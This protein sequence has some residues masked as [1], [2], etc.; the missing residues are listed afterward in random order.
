MNQKDPLAGLREDLNNGRL[1][2]L[3][4]PVS[5]Y[6]ECPVKPGDEYKLR[7]CRIVITSAN[8]MRRGGV[9]SWLVLFDRHG[10]ERTY[11]LGKAGGYVEDPKAA[12]TAQADC[13]AG[14]Q[15]E[16]WRQNPA[17]LGPPPE[18]EAVPPHI[19]DSLPS[20]K[21]TRMRHQQQKDEENQERS[22]RKDAERRIRDHSRHVFK[23][24]PADKLDIAVE[25]ISAQMRQICLELKQS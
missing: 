10:P 20:T 13:N 25:R 7:S 19:V 1:T 15:E 17:N 23:D 2:S 16:A 5:Q 6:P 21:A 8:K 14:S 12:M 9:E 11:L 4:W 22:K 18:P 24:L 3:T